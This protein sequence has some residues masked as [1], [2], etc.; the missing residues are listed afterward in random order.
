MEEIID[1]LKYEKDLYKEGIELIAGVD[2]VGRGPLIGP[3]VAAA[4]NQASLLMAEKKYAEALDVLSKSDQNDA[5]ILAAQG[6]AYINM[7][8]QAKAKAAWEKAAAKG[9]ADA[10]HNLEELDK[11]LKSL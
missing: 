8:D 10:K 7:G 5:R 11:H 4:V 2:E 1:N 9:Q 3:V 6:Y